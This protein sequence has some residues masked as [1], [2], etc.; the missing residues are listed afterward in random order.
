MTSNDQ[1]KLE[2]L[3]LTQGN[4]AEAKALYEWAKP[5]TTDT[6]RSPDGRVWYWDGMRWT[7]LEGAK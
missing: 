1:I 4:L 3:K 6:P 7:V 5:E 2:C